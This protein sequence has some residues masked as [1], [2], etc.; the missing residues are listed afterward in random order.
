MIVWSWQNSPL[1]HE[2]TL[3]ITCS[4]HRYRLVLSVEVSELFIS[5][6][7]QAHYQCPPTPDVFIFATKQLC[8]LAGRYCRGFEYVRLTQFLIMNDKND[9][10]WKNN[11]THTRRKW[12]TR[13]GRGCQRHQIKRTFLG[14]SIISRLKKDVLF[15]GPLHVVVD[16]RTSVSLLW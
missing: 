7:Q 11:V 14:Q 8:S 6:G 4:S 15:Y 2:D 12:L 13:I 5:L 16:G 3:G 1:S 10:Q 9:S